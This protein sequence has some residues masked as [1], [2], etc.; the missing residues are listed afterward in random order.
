MCVLFVGWNV[1]IKVRGKFLLVVVWENGNYVCIWGLL[2]VL[3]NVSV[4]VVWNV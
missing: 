1:E 3:V 4:L 2:F